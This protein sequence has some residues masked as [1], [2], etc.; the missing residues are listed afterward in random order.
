MVIM[1]VIGMLCFGVY[2]FSVFNNSIQHNR[3]LGK[4]LTLY[5]CHVFNSASISL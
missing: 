1:L 2:C 4:C 5:F 3:W